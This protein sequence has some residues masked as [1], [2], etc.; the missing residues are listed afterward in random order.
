MV[1]Q[2]VVQGRR[3]VRDEVSDLF[4]C[5][6][7][8]LAHRRALKVEGLLEHRNDLRERTGYFQ[9]GFEH[10]SIGGDLWVCLE[11]LELL[12]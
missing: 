8:G 2:D 1:E 4:L 11:N 5:L 10:L 6:G 7:L 12:Q 9:Q 3:Q